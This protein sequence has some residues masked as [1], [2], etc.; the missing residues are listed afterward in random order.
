MIHDPFKKTRYE[1][2]TKLCK[3]KENAIIEFLKENKTHRLNIK[4]LHDRSRDKYFYSREDST[5]QIESSIMIETIKP[6]GWVC[7]LP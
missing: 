2:I 4:V 7:P 6:L 5:L 1:L 3:A